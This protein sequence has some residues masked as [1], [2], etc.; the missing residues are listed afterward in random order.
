MA[1][2]RE[3]KAEMNLKVLTGS[4]ISSAAVVSLPLL[5]APAAQAQTS[6]W[7]VVA[8]PNASAGNNQLNAVARIAAS[9]VSAVG[10]ADHP[11]RHAQP[12]AEHSDGTSRSNPATPAGAT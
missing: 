11:A 10:A 6:P 2:L 12:L 3:G 5:L 4:I 7:T 8:S 9:D 1:K